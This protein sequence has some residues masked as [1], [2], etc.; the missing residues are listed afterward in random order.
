MKWKDKIYID[1]CL[2]FGLRSAPKLFN[3]LADLLSWIA[4]Q[5]GI[6]GILHYFDDF[7][8]IGPPHSHVCKQNLDTFMQL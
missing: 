8:I 1:G 2:P 4:A 3:I 5:E 7:L 6:S